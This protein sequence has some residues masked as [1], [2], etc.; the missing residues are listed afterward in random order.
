MRPQLLLYMQG[1]TKV[2][3]DI[4]IEVETDK[5]P[6][7]TKVVSVYCLGVLDLAFSVSDA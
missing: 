4:I 3:G 1:R 5:P 6:V 2:E 7:A